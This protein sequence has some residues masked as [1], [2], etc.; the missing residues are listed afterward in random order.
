[1]IQNVSRYCGD[2]YE[3]VANNGVPPPVSRQIHVT[4]QCKEVKLQLGFIVL[5]SN[6]SFFQL[7]CHFHAFVTHFIISAN[8]FLCIIFLPS[9]PIFV[10]VP[11]FIQ[12][13]VYCLSIFSSSPHLLHLICLSSIFFTPSRI[14]YS[15]LSFPNSVHPFSVRQSIMLYIFIHLATYIDFYIGLHWSFRL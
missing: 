12:I 5:S 8:D 14:L 7:L 11:S 4:V 15:S 2:I 6:V 3:C 1:M 13:F 10:F 9:F